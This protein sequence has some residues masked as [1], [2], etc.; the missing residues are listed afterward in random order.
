[1]FLMVV[2]FVPHQNSSC[3]HFGHILMA[4]DFESL[5]E[6][7]MKIRESCLVVTAHSVA[8]S[9]I[10]DNLCLSFQEGLET[11]LHHLQLLLVQLKTD[12]RKKTRVN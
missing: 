8:E 12:K 11:L 3:K 10:C 4:E 2:K 1:M 6:I 7:E 5:F 9:L